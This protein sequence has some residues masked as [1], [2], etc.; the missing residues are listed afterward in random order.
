MIQG[1]A[2]RSGL[3]RTLGGFILADHKD[4]HKGHR[5]RL[6]DRAALEGLDG[7]DP[8]QVMEL[9]LFYAIPRQDVSEL[10]HRLIRE[11]GSVRKALLAPQ[12]RLIAVEGVGKRVAQW[13]GALGE[14]VE[15]YGELKPE[16]RLRIVNAIS[17]FSFCKRLRKTVKA[18]CAYQICLTPA[19]VIRMCSEHCD[20]ASWGEPEYFR[21]SLKEAMAVHARN[22]IV[23]VFTQEAIPTISDYDRKSAKDY[24]CVLR[25]VNTELVDVILAG[26]EQMI[27]MFQSGDYKRKPDQHTSVLAEMYLRE[28]EAMVQYDENEL[29]DTDDGL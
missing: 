14:A 12:D 7:F 29:P 13:L 19:G 25:V 1:E 16:D 9:L 8:H 4:V 23:V 28:D 18:P 17:A 11:F 27:S 3:L 6:R 21:R 20:S 24:A 15:A 2:R 10:A 22:V 26:S 5:Q